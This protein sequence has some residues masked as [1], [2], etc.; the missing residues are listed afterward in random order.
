MGSTKAF[1]NVHVGIR[2][3][4]YMSL[5]NAKGGDGREPRGI[6]ENTGCKL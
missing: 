4:Y 5:I 1:P 2:A 6:T 3:F